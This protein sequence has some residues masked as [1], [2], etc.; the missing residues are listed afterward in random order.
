MQRDTASTHLV[1]KTKRRKCR[2]L[3]YCES[4]SMIIALLKHV[5]IASCVTF[6]AVQVSIKSGGGQSH[7]STPAEKMLRRAENSLLDEAFKQ[8]TGQQDA[9]Q[10]SFSTE[11]P[12]LASTSNP[13]KG[14]MRK[15][16]CGFDDDL[17]LQLMKQR[18]ARFREQYGREPNF[19]CEDLLGQPRQMD[20]L[21]KR[22][23]Y[24]TE[25]VRSLGLLQTVELAAPGASRS[26][27]A[28]L[29]NA[30]LSI[31]ENKQSFTL[32]DEIAAIKD[33]YEQC[34]YIADGF[35]GNQ[36]IYNVD[37]SLLCEIKK[38]KEPR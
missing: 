14:R 23:L 15:E 36:Q 2:A 1:G 21:K 38:Q 34:S 3:S 6:V 8:Q 19:S 33:A 22:G 13:Q 4:K 9:I 29:D 32:D 17:N 10:K 26:C 28:Y 37:I 5:V 7:S 31:K 27:N 20:P 24:Y 11:A 30:M 12:A 18:E 35:C 16:R 25:A